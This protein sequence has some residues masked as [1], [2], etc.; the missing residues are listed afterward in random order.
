MA[1]NPKP[2]NDLETFVLEIKNSIPSWIK[3]VIEQN[4]DVILDLQIQG[5]FDKGKDSEG[6]NLFPPYALSTKKTKRRKG[7][8]TDRVTLKDTGM[9][10][11]SVEVEVR[12]DEFELKSELYYSVYLVKKF[13]INYNIFRY[14]AIFGLTPRHLEDFTKNFIVPYIK[15][16]IN[17][18]IAE[19]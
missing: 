1:F 6:N 11:K 10:Y 8:P 16:K 2:L 9:F 13:D 14:G 4:K 7:Q 3:E 12:S 5:Q 15:I 19:S 17:D 18:K